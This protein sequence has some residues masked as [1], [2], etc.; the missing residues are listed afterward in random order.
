VLSTAIA[1]RDC[2]NCRGCL[3]R[4][5]LCEIRKFL[6]QL[7]LCVLVVLLPIGRKYEDPAAQMGGGLRYFT[8]DIIASTSGVLSR[9][10]SQSSLRS[11]ASG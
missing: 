1:I 11:S 9:R 2:A 8:L 10:P 7:P 4:G 3:Y 5:M 6:S